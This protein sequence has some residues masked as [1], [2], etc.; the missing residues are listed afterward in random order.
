VVEAETRKRK[1]KRGGGAM[2][3][4]EEQRFE[5]SRPEFVLVVVAQLAVEVPPPRVHIA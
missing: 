2:Y 5:Q 4:D 1:R 3:L